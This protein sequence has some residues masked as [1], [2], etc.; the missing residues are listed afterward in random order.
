MQQKA[1]IDR[2]IFAQLTLLS[3]LFLINQDSFILYIP[4]ERKF[5]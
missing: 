4:Y 2:K 5:F 3:Y 1:I